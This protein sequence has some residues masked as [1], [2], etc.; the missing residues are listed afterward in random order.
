MALARTLA[1]RSGTFLGGGER[2]RKRSGGGVWLFRCF[3]RARPQLAAGAAVVCRPRRTAAI[4]RYLPRRRA[5]CHLQRGA[6]ARCRMS[7]P[8]CT[9]ISRMTPGG[10]FSKLPP[11]AYGEIGFVES[12]LVGAALGRNS[13]ISFDLDQAGASALSIPGPAQS[14]EATADHRCAR[15]APPR[16]LGCRSAPSVEEADGRCISVP[17]A[18]ALE[19]TYSLIVGTGCGWGR[20]INGQSMRSHPCAG[21]ARTGLAA[22]QWRL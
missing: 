2:A 14:A 4:S 9:L 1:A 17:G 20:R 15:P 10:R 18:S 5:Y 8:A 21:I 13:R 16:C 3:Q 7:R 22:V 6:G 12:L 19:P 11:G